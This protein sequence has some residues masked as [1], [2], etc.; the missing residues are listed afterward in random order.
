MLDRNGEK[1]LS[2]RSLAKHL[3]VTPMA[4]SHHVGTRHEM[5]SSIVA[6]VYDGIGEPVQDG[7]PHDCLRALLSDYCKRVLAHPNVALL[8]LSDTSLLKGPLISLNE[9]ICS[10]IALLVRSKS[11]VKTVL[12]VVADYTHGFAIAAATAKAQKRP[13]LKGFQRG[14]DWILERI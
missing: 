2:F 10:N 14:L 5:L 7:T 1:G 11:E 3:G 6:R 8:V 12:D 4:I 13:T 9:R